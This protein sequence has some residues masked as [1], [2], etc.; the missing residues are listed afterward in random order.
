MN[1]A[2][3]EGNFEWKY[4][5]PIVSRLLL[6]L[7]DTIKAADTPPVLKKRIPDYII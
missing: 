7:F 2:D 4:E 5:L 3:F 6:N 1:Y